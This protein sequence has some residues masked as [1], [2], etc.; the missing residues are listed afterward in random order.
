MGVAL[1][2]VAFVSKAA[3]GCSQTT[4]GGTAAHMYAHHP[5]PQVGV[6]APA[7]SSTTDPLV[8]NPGGGGEAS[9][10]G[11]AESGEQAAAAAG[12]GELDLDALLFKA[13]L[14]LAAC[15]SAAMASS[16]LVG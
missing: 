10:S 16:M 6:P 15:C 13:F 5:T 3:R 1:K 14:L 11:G 8:A 7:S 12:A 9:V 4:A 2:T